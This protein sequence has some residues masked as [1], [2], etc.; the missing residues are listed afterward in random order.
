MM[1]ATL[2]PEEGVWLAGPVGEATRSSVHRWIRTGGAFDAV[3]DLDAAVRR[4]LRRRLQ[5]CAV[6]CR[7]RSDRCGAG[8]FVAG[9]FHANYVIASVV[10]EAISVFDHEIASSVFAL[11]AMTPFGGKLKRDDAACQMTKIICLR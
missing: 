9:N 3:V 7:R 2:T 6:Q 4:D 1:G 5:R 8:V 11:L 10:C